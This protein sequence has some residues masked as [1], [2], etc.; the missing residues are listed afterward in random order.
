[1]DKKNKD[2]NEEEIIKS[3]DTQIKELKKKRTDL[4]NNTI[5]E[6]FSIKKF[7]KGMFSLFNGVEWTKSLKELGLFDVR[8][9]IIYALIIG[10]IYGYG[11][12]KGV[13]NKPVHFD[14]EGKEATISLNKHYLK[15]ERDGTAKVIDKDGN[16]LKV[17]KTKDIPEL[18]KALKPI[19]IDIHPFFTAGG[20]LGTS[21]NSGKSD[22]G[23]EAGAG[24][25]LFKFY[26]IHLNTWLTNRGFYLGPDYKLTDNFG[27]IGGIGKGFKGS[28][29]V[30]FG[31]KWEF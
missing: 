8:K 27:I 15:I 23:F 24:L 25:S 2:L 6:G 22:A 17:I 4:A 30:Y 21:V 29:R 9:W 11:Y 5:Y 19:G 7:L 20:S 28:N 3:L 16:I 31:G 14:M 1:M 10:S 12:F 13:G 18:Q 26:K